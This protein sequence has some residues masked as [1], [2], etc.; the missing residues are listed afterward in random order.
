MEQLRKITLEQNFL[1]IERQDRL[2]HGYITFWLVLSAIHNLKSYAV[3][4]DAVNI[5][6]N[7]SKKGA[8]KFINM[9]YIV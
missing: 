9:F 4:N 2:D 8:E 7:C 6:K 5:A 3:V 1:Y